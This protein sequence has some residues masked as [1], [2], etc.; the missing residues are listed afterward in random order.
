IARDRPDGAITASRLACALV[1]IASVATT[2]SVV[3]SGVVPFMRGA[4]ICDE[5][6]LGRPRLPNSRS[7]SNGAAQNQGPAPTV[8]LPT[9]FT[10][11]SAPTV[12]P[13]DVWPEAEPR[14]PLQFAV[15]APVPAPTL[16]SAKS[17]P[18][19]AAAA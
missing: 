9:A 6:A 17:K 15:V 18:A 10:A 3:F 7:T 11:A 1:R 19:P 16:P 13:S 12:Q 4:S 8:T 2:T 5:K 14:P